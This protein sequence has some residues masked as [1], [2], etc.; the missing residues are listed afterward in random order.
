[1]ARASEERSFVDDL[2]VDLSRFHRR[3]M[4]LVFPRQVGYEDSPMG[5]WTPDTQGE[6]YRF[7]A[8]GALGALVVGLTYPFVLLGVATRFYARKFDALAAWLGVIGVI[9]AT[10]AAWGAL[11][12]YARAQFTQEGFLAVAAAG[13][14]AVVSA[15]LAMLFRYLDGRPV[16]VLLAYP[17]GVTAVFLPPVVAA[18]YSPTLADLVFPRSES[19]AAYV[20]DTYLAQ[21]GLAEPIRDRFDLVGVA[22][23]AMWFGIAVPVG[24]ALGILVSLANLIRP[25]A[26]DDE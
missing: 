7:L 23:V 8:W 15:A 6:R 22:Y 11:A 21:F 3:W 14:V 1:M 5:R 26:D 18:L 9:L 10:G 25:T 12:L 13:S 24:W 20:L 17:F 2:K 4:G 19:L 16:T